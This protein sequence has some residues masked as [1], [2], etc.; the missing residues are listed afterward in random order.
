[1]PS[2]HGT[3]TPS[4]VPP[5]VRE[6]MDE[7]FRLTGVS[8]TAEAATSRRWR[9]THTNARVV[10]TYD[11]KTTSPGRWQH[12]GSTLT[13]DGHRRPLAAHAKHYAQIFAD[14]DTAPSNEDAGAGE[15]DPQPRSL[16]VAPTSIQRY[17]TQID[18]LLPTEHA[19]GVAFIP[20]CNVWILEIST[21]RATA[22]LRFVSAG[23]DRSRRGSQWDLDLAQP[24]QLVVDGVDRSVEVG[25]RF[26]RAMELMAR[27]GEQGPLAG[28]PVAGPAPA[29]RSNA[30]QTRRAT[31]IRV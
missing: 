12:A 19:V 14:P 25:S 21:D 1:M 23:R 15:E 20:G 9:I 31:V 3:D 17:R 26:T 7:L 10:M 27:P 16:E 8:A 6:M 22:R 28:G 2:T 11:M 24:I 13:V 5:Q 30:V 29:A 4:F 18:A